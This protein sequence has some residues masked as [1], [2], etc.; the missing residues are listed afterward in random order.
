MITLENI[1]YILIFNKENGYLHYIVY[2]I[3][4]DMKYILYEIY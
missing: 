2:Y 1:Q 3:I 4:E